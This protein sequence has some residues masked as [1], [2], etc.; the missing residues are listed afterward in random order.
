MKFAEI[1]PK[2]PM[3]RQQIERFVNHPKVQHIIVFLIVLNAALLGLETSP[4]VMQAF[5]AELV[6]LDHAILA[7]FILE[8]LLLIAARGM[9]EAESKS[10][11]LRINKRD[12]S[13]YQNASLMQKDCD[14]TTLLRESLIFS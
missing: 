11:M 8:I 12:L 5:G 2:L 3:W 9:T 13:I 10:A 14:C 1:D 7:V 4:A 6:I